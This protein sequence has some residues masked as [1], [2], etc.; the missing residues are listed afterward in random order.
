MHLK[1]VGVPVTPRPEV[2]NDLLCL[3]GVQCQVVD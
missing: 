3:S 1:G 2:Q